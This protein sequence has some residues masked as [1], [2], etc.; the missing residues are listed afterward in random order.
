[1]KKTI[2]I[3]QKMID[4]YGVI[5]GDNDI[6]HYDDAYAR[7]RGF[8]GTLAHGLMVLGYAVEMATR[9]YGK[10]WIYRGEIEVK[11]VGPTCPGDDLEV[12]IPDNGNGDVVAKVAQAGETMVGKLH[13]RT[14]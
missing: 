7:E 8:R 9:K 3:T 5:N 6:L 14:A 10:D 13:L 12:A 1:M 2:R 4:D 11:F